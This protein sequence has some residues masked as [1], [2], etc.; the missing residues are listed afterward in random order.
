MA[1][2]VSPAV[3]VSEIDLT[4][5]VPAVS[6]TNAGMAGIFRWGPLNERVLISDET[7]L[8]SR[9]HKPTT[10]NFETFFTAASFLAY[11]NSLYVVR[12][13]S[14]SG[15]SA[16][17]ATS[18]ATL[19]SNTAGTGLLVKNDL[20]Y[21]S[22][23]EDG[24]GNV[25]QFVAKYPGTM[26]NSLKV[27]LCH[28][29]NA[30]ESSL[31]SNIA[32]TTNTTTLTGNTSASTFV[33]ELEPGDIVI[34]G[35]DSQEIKVQTV[36]NSSS[37]VLASKYTGTTITI[38]GTNSGTPTRRWAYYNKFQR[39]PGTSDYANARNGQLDEMHVAVVDEDGLWTGANNTV[40]EAYSHVSSAGDAKQPDG[41]TNFYKDLINNTSSYVR[42]MDHS[43]AG[44]N[45]GS[46]AAGLT[47]GVQYKPDYF[48]L[49]GGSDGGPSAGSGTETNLIT[50][51]DAQRGYAL[52]RDAD[53]VDVSIILAGKARGT[54]SNNV[55]TANYIIDNVISE[56][57]DAVVVISPDQADVVNND[58]GEVTA[59]KT[60]RNAL[61][62]SS[63]AIL[64]SGY[65]RMYDKY[66]DVLRWV[67]LNG[68][69]AGT[70]VRTDDLRDAWWSPAGLNR[71]QIKNVVKLAWQPRKSERDELYKNDINPVI[72]KQ[73][74][75]TIL[76]GDKT[77]LGK[78][79]A[80]DRI[81]VR[82]LFIVLEKAISTAAEFSLFEFNDEFTRASFKN[83]VE[84]FLRDVQGRRGITD[85]RVVCDE[86]NNT[87]E[88][89]DRNEFVGDIYVKPARSINFIQLNFVAV[90]NGV[91]F[92]EVVG[93]F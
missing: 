31:T 2:Q 85:F 10:T 92:E 75:G 62:T 27:S 55:G 76:Y 46:D 74:Q 43:G 4:T 26:G 81:N 78:P 42:W 86:T 49:A 35:A 58:A 54:D 41:T 28:S 60:F 19:G 23:Y 69:V 13:A 52:F 40:L 82:R 37:V 80:F 7:Q 24:S 83:L 29:A 70:M 39:A 11:A 12:V 73:G 71:G 48:S 77:L 8:V 30:F 45:Y 14:E 87:A 3:N 1:F 53:E 63:Y 57:K 33:T 84:P 72:T 65:K 9:F 38:N 44:T 20:H 18:E 17:N 90:R 89:I 68:D 6:T 61:S 93:K 88:V 32:I 67:P 21:T 66:N 15:N 25:G 59:I 56:R 51:S 50:Q 64:D 16:L 34:L 36:T 79:S 47:F 91:D 5:I 22:N